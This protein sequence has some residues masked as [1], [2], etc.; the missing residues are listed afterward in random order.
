[1]CQAC[2]CPTSGHELCQM[3]CRGHSHL[4]GIRHIWNNSFHQ[5]LARE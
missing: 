3:S 2:K 4:H 1:M 5:L